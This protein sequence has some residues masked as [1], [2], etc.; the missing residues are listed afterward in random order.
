MR[1]RTWLHKYVTAVLAPT[2]DVSVEFLV[3]SGADLL[4][5]RRVLCLCHHRGRT[6]RSAAY[7]APPEAPKEDAWRRGSSQSAIRSVPKMERPAVRHVTALTYCASSVA[8]IDATSLFL[9]T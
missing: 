8:K 3:R 9:G 6:K 5:S 1:I 7:H 4:S 2:L